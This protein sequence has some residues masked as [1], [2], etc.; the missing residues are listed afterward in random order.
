MVTGSG[1][2]FGLLKIPPTLPGVVLLDSFGIGV[3]FSNG[4]ILFFRPSP[5]FE[6]IFPHPMVVKLIEIEPT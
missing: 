4:Y 2:M 5:A 6:G 3:S 1:S